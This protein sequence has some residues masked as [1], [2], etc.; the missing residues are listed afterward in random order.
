LRI[1]I[2]L[3]VNDPKGGFTMKNPKA[4]AKKNHN[5]EEKTKPGHNDRAFDILL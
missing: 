4:V 1:I 5:N 2:R 3:T